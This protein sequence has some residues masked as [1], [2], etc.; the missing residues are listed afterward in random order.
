MRWASQ[1]AEHRVASKGAS[2]G[3]AGAPGSHAVQ[4]RVLGI[5]WGVRGD[6]AFRPLHSVVDHML[7]LA[8][9]DSAIRKTKL[10]VHMAMPAGAKR[11][12]DGDILALRTESAAARAPPAMFV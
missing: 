10:V 11:Q 8:S 2:V 6:H 12:S 9:V 3:Q 1:C 4:R 7:E 5:D